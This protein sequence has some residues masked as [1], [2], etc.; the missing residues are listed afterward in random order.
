M[1]ESRSTPAQKNDAG[2]DVGVRKTVAASPDAV[3]KFLLGDGLPM[4]LGEI[5]SLPSKKG[6]RYRTNDGV[7]GTIRSFTNGKQVRMTWQPEDWPHETTLQVT[8]A[9][10]PAG[11]GATIEFRQ[12]ELADRD[13]RRMMLGHWHNVSDSLVAHFG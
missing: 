6:V 5:E 1:S 8:V 11:A 7:R 4:W 9:N 13:E 3:W 10:A 2:W 12:E